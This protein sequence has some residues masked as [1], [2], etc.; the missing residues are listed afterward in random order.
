MYSTHAIPF[1]NIEVQQ[2][3]LSLSHSLRVCSNELIF[4]S[5]KPHIRSLFMYGGVKGMREA[6]RTEIESYII[7]LTAKFI[8]CYSIFVENRVGVCVYVLVLLFEI[9]YVR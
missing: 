9:G 4:K 7:R 2:K 1:A 5:A 3:Y 8:I 6:K